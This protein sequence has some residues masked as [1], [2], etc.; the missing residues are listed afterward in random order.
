LPNHP[1]K[2]TKRPE[3]TE[4]IQPL[5]DLRGYQI[6]EFRRYSIKAGDRARFSTYFDAF[7]PDAFQQQSV[8]I[9]GSFLDRR[10]P[11]GFI[12]I[13]GF[14]NNFHRGRAS[15]DFY[16]GPLW[17][18]RRPLMLSLIDDA[19]DVRQFTPVAP[20]RGLP[21]LPP[22][23]PVLEAR[24][25]R[26]SVV[27][28][29]FLTEPSRVP[30]LVAGLERTR[31]ELGNAGLHELG[32]LMTLMAP[33]TFPQHTLRTDGHYLLWFGVTPEPL[34]DGSISNQLERSLA[35]LADATGA[36]TKA[37]VLDLE[38][39]A[40]SRIRWFEGLDASSLSRYPR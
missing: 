5:D 23:D 18:E 39:T 33:N 25:S 11:N 8:M 16:Y 30:E 24:T 32:T 9:F 26:G 15:A 31:I 10:D 14:L 22:V 27:C 36:F 6:V 3:V 19:S 13:R 35:R 4:T 2:H 12:W 29:I 34:V 20:G 17:K 28:A 7:F 40:R 1:L 38:P 37:E 21:I